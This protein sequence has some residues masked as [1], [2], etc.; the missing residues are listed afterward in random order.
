L[1]F[2]H[3]AG[4]GEQAADR[5]PSAVR[6]YDGGLWPHRRLMLASEHSEWQLRADAPEFYRNPANGRLREGFRMPAWRERSTL[7]KGPASESLR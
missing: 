2:E 1:A 6:G 4:D 3:V 5:Q 7:G